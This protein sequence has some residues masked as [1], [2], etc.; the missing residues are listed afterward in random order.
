MTKTSLTDFNQ[1]FLSFLDNSPTPFHAVSTLSAQLE[2][3][4]F[5]RLDEL[6]AWGA[7]SAGQ[8]YV[9]RNDSSIIAFTL[10]KPSLAETGFHM[11]GAHT[12]SPCLK[13]KPKPEKVKHTLMQLGVEVYG[14]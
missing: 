9:T 1:N 6:D 10:P 12:D 5:E 3:N 2:A 11:V 4:G 13:V 7:L 8:Y 14:G